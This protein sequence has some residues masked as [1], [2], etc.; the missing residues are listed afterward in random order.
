MNNLLYVGR[1]VFLT[2]LISQI[3]IL[4]FRFSA[5]RNK[6][7]FWLFLLVLISLGIKTF[8]SRVYFVGIGTSLLLI[9]ITGNFLILISLGK[10]NYLWNIFVGLIAASII[11]LMFLGRTNNIYFSLYYLFMM[12]VTF[13]YPLQ[14]LW[15]MYKK[16]Q[17]KIFIYLLVCSVLLIL[18]RGTDLFFVILMGTSYDITL[19]IS[20]LLI[21]GIG[22]MIFQQGYLVDE[23]LYG[24]AVNL[25]KKERLVRDVFS[26]VIQTENTLILQDRLITNG[27]LSTGTA[28]EFK[29]ILTHIIL[30][31]QAGLA[32]DQH[33][34]KDIIFKS[35]LESAEHGRDIIV[36]LLDRLVLK[37]GEEPVYINIKKD[38][39]YLF[40]IMRV[41]YGKQ[42]ISF[43]YDIDEGACIFIGK[44]E[45][46]QIIINLTRNAQ[47]VLKSIQNLEKHIKIKVEK[48]NDNVIIEV[49]DNG[50]GVP[51]DKI[52]EIFKPHFSRKESSGLGL[53]LVKM[54]VNNNKGS[55]EYIHGSGGA[56]FRILFPPA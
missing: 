18:S 17:D 36:K 26:R 8:F 23:G 38:L 52:D 19:W 7:E 34:N 41:A 42:G 40:N 24:Y 27:L 44:G 16:K 4:I 37:T 39:A 56:H 47:E 46:E 30:L 35:V 50:Y 6:K 28:H 51:E 13:I 43:E 11:F 21:C 25:R 1:I 3:I 20:I 2:L 14:K 54:L 5:C 31:A 32:K 29:N 45:L 49:I 22:F 55:I 12:I 9:Y 48:A 53:Y 15:E 33:K 10:F